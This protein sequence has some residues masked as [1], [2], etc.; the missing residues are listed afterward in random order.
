MARKEFYKLSLTSSE[1]IKLF[2]CNKVYVEIG[3]T[4]NDTVL[5]YCFLFSFLLNAN[6]EQLKRCAYSAFDAVFLYQGFQIT[7]LIDLKIY[8]ST[9]YPGKF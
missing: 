6:L 5:R 1:K 4:I 7:L 3:N 2:S 9:K 8:W